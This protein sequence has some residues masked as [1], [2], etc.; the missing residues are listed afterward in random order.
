MDRKG[1][2]NIVLFSNWMKT[3]LGNQRIEMVFECLDTHAIVYLNDSAVLGNNMF[4]EWTID[5]KQDLILG[6]NKLLVRFIS[7]VD[8][9]QS[10][11]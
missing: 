6:E 4:R 9:I 10:M 1:E 3:Y 11:P 7:P 8:M 2:R 5:C